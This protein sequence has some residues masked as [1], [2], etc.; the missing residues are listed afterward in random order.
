MQFTAIPNPERIYVVSADRIS[1]TKLNFNEKSR[2]SASE[3]LELLCALYLSLLY[4]D[5][6]ALLFW[7]NKIY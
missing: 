1:S 2:V 5:Y 4:A 3:N 7:L 6:E